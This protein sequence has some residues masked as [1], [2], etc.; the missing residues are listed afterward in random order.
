M[1]GTCTGCP[2]LTTEEWRSGTAYMCIKG[3]SSY[4]ARKIDLIRGEPVR[5]AWCKDKGEDNET[6]A[7][8]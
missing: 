2:H 1:S 5:P 4:P 7:Q 3:W 8:N 6:D